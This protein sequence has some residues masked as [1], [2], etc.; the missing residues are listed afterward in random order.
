[1][2]QATATNGY[3]R[4]HSYDS[5][6]R[7]AGSVANPGYSYAPKEVPLGDDANGN[8]TSGAGSSLTW[9]SFN[10]PAALTKGATTD[11]FLYGSEHQRIRQVSPAATT[12]YL[13]TLWTKRD[14]DHLIHWPRPA[15][16]ILYDCIDGKGSGEICDSRLFREFD[17]IT[18]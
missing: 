16:S 2:C 12:L 14:M 13:Y 1:M 10:M 3:S 17:R 4:T 15:F 9:T 6:G 11:N 8:L 7:L 5:L 18:E